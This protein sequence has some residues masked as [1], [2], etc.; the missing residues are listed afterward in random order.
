MNKEKRLIQ[1]SL[2]LVL[3]TLLISCDNFMVK[4]ILPDRT[5]NPGNRVKAIDAGDQ[6]SLALMEDGSLRA[7]GQNMYRKL[8]DGTTTN[9]S[10]PVKV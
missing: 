8:G 9:H 7:W 4:K 6:H 10:Y 1:Y 3:C 2:F 5:K